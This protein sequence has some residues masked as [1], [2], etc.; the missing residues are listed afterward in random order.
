M[1]SNQY[2]RSACRHFL[3][4]YGLGRFAWVLH[5]IPRRPRCALCSRKIPTPAPRRPPKTSTTSPHP[6]T[7]AQKISPTLLLFSTKDCHNSGPGRHLR[8]PFQGLS[9]R[10]RVHIPQPNSAITAGGRDCRAVLTHQHGRNPVPAK[11]ENFY[12]SHNTRVD[13]KYSSILTRGLRV[14]L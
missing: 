10:A 4:T 8:M 2:Y 14:A 3:L 9:A 13:A 12:Y 5:T 1:Y 7:I 6:C 11:C